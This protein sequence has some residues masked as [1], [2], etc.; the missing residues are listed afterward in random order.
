MMD[1]MQGMRN[2]RLSLDTKFI[3]MQAQLGELKTEVATLKADM[4]TKEIF[5]SL[6]NR[7]SKLEAGGAPNGEVSRL[8]S[9]AGRL[10][11]PH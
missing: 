3:S 7:V 10:D 5:E 8:Q 11:L 2:M 9:Q 4:M 6:E 1:L